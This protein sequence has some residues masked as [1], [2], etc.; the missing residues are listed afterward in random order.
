MA[1]VNNENHETLPTLTSDIVAAMVSNNRVEAALVPQFIQSVYQ[2][3]CGLG[4]DA[5]DKE[6][7]EPAVPIR[8]SIK[9]DHLVCLE[10]GKKM[11]MLKRHLM[12]EHGMTPGE[13]RALG[14]EQG[15]PDG[16]AR[17]RQDAQRSGGQNRSRTSS[18]QEGRAPEGEG[19][20]YR[21][22]LLQHGSC[23]PQPRRRLGGKLVVGRS[24]AGGKLWPAPLPRR[25]SMRGTTNDETG[26]KCRERA[27]RV[28]PR[29]SNR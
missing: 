28:D 9:K 7:Q 15:L 24:R 1:E 2:S 23:S 18:R 20:A 10:D 6:S 4:A 19:G 13:Y 11:K 12:T 17:I 16:G 14:V 3:L 8:S 22:A 5:E 21:L 29:I 26:P 25:W 27:R